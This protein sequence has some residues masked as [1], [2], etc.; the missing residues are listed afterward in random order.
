MGTKGSASMV[1]RPVHPDEA[2]DRKQK[3][4]PA[5]SL[6]ELEQ[7]QELIDQCKSS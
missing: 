6:K 2:E 5:F 7:A 3:P 1:P 4:I